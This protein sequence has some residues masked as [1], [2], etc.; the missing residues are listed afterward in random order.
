MDLEIDVSSTEAVYEQIVRQ[1]Q[2]GVRLGRLAPGAAL[3]SIRQFA[4][5]LALNPNTVA[6][7]YKILEQHRVIRTAGRKGTFISPDAA[8]HIDQ[9]THRDAG[10][11][12]GELVGALAGRGMSAAQIKAALHAAL[13]ALPAKKG[14]K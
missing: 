9:H 11:L 13:E 1:I 12:M 6:R 8:S 14:K 2:Q 3:P 7:A 5:D 4:D 10:F